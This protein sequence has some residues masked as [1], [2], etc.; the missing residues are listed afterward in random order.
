MFSDGIE[1]MVLHGATKTVN[2]SFFEQ[3]F[4]AVRASKA[5]GIDQKL[6]EK[7]KEY[8]GS[9]AVNARTNDD[10]SLLMATRRPRIK[11]P[12]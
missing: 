9:P 10:K 3:M 5:R 6:S 2:D 8:L 11:V 7:L 4:V 1:R 12:T